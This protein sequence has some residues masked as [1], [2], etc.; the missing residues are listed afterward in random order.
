MALILKSYIYNS[1]KMAMKSIKRILSFIL[2][3]MLMASFSQCSTTQK[4]QSKAP[5]QFGDVYYQVLT[6]GV[7]GGG[8]GLN[9]FIQVRDNSVVFDSVF[10][11]E[12]GTKLVVSPQENGLYI[13]RFQTETNQAKTIILSSDPKEEYANKMPEKKEKIPFQLN[14]DE[15]VVSYKI[16]SQVLYYKISNVVQK[17]P[18][19]YPNAPQKKMK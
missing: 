16:E 10:F 15:C 7:Q 9:I 12:Q 19:N 4:L 2:M 18:L 3:L 14:D 17:E 8:S 11:R 5:V 13:G 6:A 1:D